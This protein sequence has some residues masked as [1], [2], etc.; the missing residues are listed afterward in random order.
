VLRRKALAGRNGFRQARPVSGRSLGGLNPGLLFAACIW[1]TA[2][3]SLIA[4]MTSR[5]PGDAGVMPA[6]EGNPA[7]GRPRTGD[8]P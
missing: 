2:M 7:D 4:C 3:L 1:Q 5:V 8:L 6:D